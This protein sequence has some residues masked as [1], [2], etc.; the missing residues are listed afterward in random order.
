MKSFLTVQTRRFQVIFVDIIL[1]TLYLVCSYYLVIARKYIEYVSID[2]PT[3]C[4]K[5]INLG[6]FSSPS[7]LSDKILKQLTELPLHRNSIGWI[8]EELKQTL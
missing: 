5:L 4:L 6:I 3:K 2:N 7:E 1:L 8:L